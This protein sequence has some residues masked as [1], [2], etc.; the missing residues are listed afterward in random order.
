MI[1]CGQAANVFAFADPKKPQESSAS[2]PT[3]NPTL[4]YHGTFLGTWA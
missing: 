4:A 1:T 2:A 3:S